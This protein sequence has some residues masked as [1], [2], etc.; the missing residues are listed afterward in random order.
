MKYDTKKLRKNILKYSKFE[1]ENEV[2]KPIKNFEKYYEVSN[3]GRYRNLDRVILK[4]NGVKQFSK[5]KFLKNN[6]YT[7]GYTQLILVVDKKRYNFI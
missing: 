4:S 3:L 5:S 6:Y 2:W 7:N 1:I